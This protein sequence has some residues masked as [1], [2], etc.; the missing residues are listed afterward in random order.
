MRK[1]AAIVVFLIVAGAAV[2]NLV[3]AWAFA[4]SIQGATTSGP[5]EWSEQDRQYLQCEWTISISKRFGITEV[6]AFN[7]ATPCPT[8]ELPPSLRPS[9]CRLTMLPEVI[10]AWESRTERAFGW[11]F[12][13]FW[14]VDYSSAAFSAVNMGAP[15]TLGHRWRL[16]VAP[17]VLG[18][19]SGTVLYAAIPLMAMCVIRERLKWYR[20]RRGACI[21]CGYDRRRHG[22]VEPCPECGRTPIC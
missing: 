4:L 18:I 9:W 1:R 10:E 12:R 15:W 19:V 22:P 17:C 13:T 20:R 21:A 11:P 5:L 8:F 14:Y 2:L 6:H 3:V 7:A 16:P